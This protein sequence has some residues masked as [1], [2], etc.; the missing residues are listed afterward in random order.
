MHLRELSGTCRLLSDAL[1][2]F[3]DA[4]V[5]CR[6]GLHLDLRAGQRRILEGEIRALERRRSEI[7]ACMGVVASWFRQIPVPPRTEA[8]AIAALTDEVEALMERAESAERALDVA[9][10]VL[11]LADR[12]QGLLHPIDPDLTP[13]PGK[14]IPGLR[15][16]PIADGRLAPGPV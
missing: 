15:T 11:R 1:V 8:A 7:A 3:D 5:V 10:R 13:L 14:G 2:L 12:V 4:I 9:A 6:Q 16:T